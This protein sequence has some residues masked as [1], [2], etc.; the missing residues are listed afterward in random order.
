[1]E[2][3]IENP[4]PAR[5]EMTDV[6]NAVF[7]GTDAVMLSG[8][9]R[10]LVGPG[11]SF[12]THLRLSGPSV[13]GQ[14]P[15]DDATLEPNFLCACC[16]R[17]PQ[18]LHP[19]TT[20]CSICPRPRLTCTPSLTRVAPLK[21]ETANGKHPALVVRTMSDI[22][23]TSE[24]GVSYYEQFHSIRCAGLRDRSGSDDFTAE[25]CKVPLLCLRC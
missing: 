16:C 14:N 24:L 19:S 10:E 17:C 3:M 5:A 22:V 9:I 12:C 8:G 6:A 13:T 11:G 20:F 15:V 1:M 21:G 2:S 7:D 4:Y 18:P 23:A 25:P